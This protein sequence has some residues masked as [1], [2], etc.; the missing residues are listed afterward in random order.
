[1]GNFEKLFDFPGWMVHTAHG[2]SFLLGM[3]CFME[4]GVEEILFL[5]SL[6]ARGKTK[7]I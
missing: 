5:Y 2:I 7:N 6:L 3:A 4:H 1:M